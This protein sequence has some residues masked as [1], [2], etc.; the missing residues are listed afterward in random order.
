MG[1]GGKNSRYAALLDFFEHPAI[2]IIMAYVAL[3]SVV[4]I[5]AEIFLPLTEGMRRTLYIVDAVAVAILAADYAYRAKASGD[6]WGYIKK[7]FYEI[8]ALIPAFLLT[9]LEAKLAGAGLLRF[10]RILRVIRIFV[11]ISRGSRFLRLFREVLRD[12]RFME[13]SLMIVLTILTGSFAVY[14][15]ESIHEDSPIQTMGDAVWWAMATATTV[16]YGDVVPVTSLG[17]AIGVLMMIL[18][19]SLLSVFISAVG[20]AFYEYTTSYFRSS[21][22]TRINERIKSIGGLSEDELEELIADVRRL[23]ESKRRS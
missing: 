13:F 2:E 12:V 4:I 19:I 3:I 21:L 1:G 11:F 22:E 7:N 18:G 20:A 16:G 17:R 14:L 6:P 15:V 23:W 8:P 10:V 9:L 5:L